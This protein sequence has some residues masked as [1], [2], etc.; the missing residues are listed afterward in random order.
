MREFEDRSIFRFSTYETK[1]RILQSCSMQANSNSPTTF[2]ASDDNLLMDN[3]DKDV[4]E[5]VRRVSV[6]SDLD[7]SKGA[8]KP[9]LEN[10][11]QLRTI[12]FP[13]SKG[14]R[15]PHELIL[16][17]SACDTIFSTFMGLRVLILQDLGMKALPASIGKLKS[18]RYLDLSYNNMK[19]LPN[20]IGELKHLQTLILSHCHEL[21]ELPNDVNYFVSLRHLELEECL[22]LTHM[23]SAL[24][25]LT[26]LRTLS[27]FVASS[28]SKKNSQT[29]GLWEL[30][31][32][33]NL[34]G[35]LEILHL[36]RFSKE[37]GQYGHNYLNGK[38]HLQG[39]TLRWNH[40]HNKRHNNDIDDDSESLRY[41]EPHPNLEALSIV[42]Y[43]GIK[44]SDWL[45]SLVNL[46]KF[47]LYN[48]SKCEKLPPLDRLPKLES[49]L[50]EHTQNATKCSYLEGSRGMTAAVTE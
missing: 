8:P 19:K 15:V 13:A 1:H 50:I 28:T 5:S 26:S 42:G 41:L 44:F 29:G 37:L 45:L 39:L 48:C 16:S 33:N 21:T 36:E 49:L 4:K 12:L 31:D 20:C 32:L 24:K 14:S 6:T 2:V 47:S 35:E 18:L 38:Q 34:R 43:E 9:L 46:V 30:V 17:W 25:V 40:D 7:F 23:P 3:P 10:A 11:T 27:H 22:H